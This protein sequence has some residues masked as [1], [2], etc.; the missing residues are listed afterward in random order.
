MKIEKTE[1]NLS[2]EDFS[3]WI[4]KAEKSPVISLEEFNEKWEEKIL[5]IKKLHLKESSLLLK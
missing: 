2:K 5:Q 4:K 3:N 1:N